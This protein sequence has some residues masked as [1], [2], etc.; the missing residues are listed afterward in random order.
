MP[1]AVTRIT[2]EHI[3]GD[4]TMQIDRWVENPVAIP[5]SHRISSLVTVTHA[6][7]VHLTDENPYR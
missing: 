7:T 3:H 4:S 2:D 5:T 1:S 6:L